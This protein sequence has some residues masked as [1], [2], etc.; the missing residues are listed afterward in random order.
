MPRFLK[1]AH[2]RKSDGSLFTEADLAA[3]EALTR[4]LREIHPGPVVGEE[5]TEEQQVERWLGGRCAAC[6]ASIR[7]T[8]PR[9][10]V[11]GLPYFAVSV[12][13]MQQ[14]AACWAWCTIR[15]PTR[16]SMPSAAAAPF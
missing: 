4:A 6:G 5:M 10:F 3:Q 13:L 12:A 9:N 8:A 7:S 1:V 15:W 16:C 11:Y 14:G 2:Q